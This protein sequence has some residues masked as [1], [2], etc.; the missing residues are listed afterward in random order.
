MKRAGLALGGLGVVVAVAA[1]APLVVTG[2][3]ARLRGAQGLCLLAAAIGLALAVGLGGLP[4]LGQG[5]FVGLGAY[6]AAIMRDHGRGPVA[7]TGAGIVVA[8]AAGLV[9]ALGITRFR[10][11]LIALTTWLAGWM[12]NIAVGAFPDLTGGAQGIVIGPVEQRV[13][14]LGITA[15]AGPVALFEISL[16]AAL[17]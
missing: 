6:A 13:G 1:L 4:S 8:S 10:P 15:T 16:L 5:A 12:F 3:H 14:A 2:A 11:A 17:L 9:L 7:A